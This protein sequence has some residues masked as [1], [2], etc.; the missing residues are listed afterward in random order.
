MN[1]GAAMANGNVLLFLHADTRLPSNWTKMVGE[2]LS[3]CKVALGAFNFGV[4][5][6]FPGKRVLE[7]AVNWRSRRR[8]LPYGD[9]ALFLRRAIF[10]EEGGFADLPIM[11]DF[12]FVR[13]L[14][15]R[16]R[17]IIAP[18]T[19]VTSGRRWRR[20]GLLRTTLRNQFVIAGY[21]VGISPHK[22][23]RFYRGRLNGHSSQ[24]PRNE[25]NAT[26]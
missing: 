8:Q 5:G 25:K 20:S 13:R 22:L 9:Q 12:E 26:L 15:R 16:G 1:A 7:R 14:R 21:Q 18:G 2:S 10:E 24:R 17:V 19:A 3:T 11:E 4:A 23:A 6:T